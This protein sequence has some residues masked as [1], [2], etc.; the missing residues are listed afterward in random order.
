MEKILMRYEFHCDGCGEEK[1]FFKS[2]K[3]G[4][5]KK[6]ICPRCTAKA[7][8]KK[9]F[10]RHVMGGNFILKGDGWAGKDLK[11]AERQNAIATEETEAMLK[12]DADNQRIVEEVTEIRRQG[13]AAT[14]Q[15]KRDKPQKFKDYESALSEGYR[16]EPKSYNLKSSDI[17]KANE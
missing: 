6:V 14:E 5:P 1:E 17:K 10:M 15:L 8:G 7:G 16:A 3:D 4:P 9:I 2:I 11:R 12:R 13:S